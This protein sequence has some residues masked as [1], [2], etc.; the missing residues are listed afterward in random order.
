LLYLEIDNKKA[1]IKNLKKKVF[2]HA[3]LGLKIITLR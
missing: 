2:H 3:F 1:L